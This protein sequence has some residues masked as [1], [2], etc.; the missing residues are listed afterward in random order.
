MSNC[1]KVTSE[2]L[3]AFAERCRDSEEPCYI[4]QDDP[5]SRIDASGL[6]LAHVNLTGANLTDA[7]LTGADLTRAD[8]TGVDFTKKQHTEANFEGAYFT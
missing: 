5:D 1:I 4:V 7:N 2:S 3:E 8:I 6:D